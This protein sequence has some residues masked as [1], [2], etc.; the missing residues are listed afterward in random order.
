MEASNFKT[1]LKGRIELLFSYDRWNIGYIE[2]T[3]ESLIRTQKLNHNVYW[4]KEGNPEY[5][6]DPFPINIDNQLHIYY[7]EMSFWRGKGQLMMINTLDYKSKKKITGI[8]KNEIHLS[9]PYLFEDQGQWYCL[10]ETSEIEEV[11]LFKIDKK[12]PEKLHKL[13]PILSGKRYVDS[14]II[15][16]QDK[17]WLFTT[18]SGKPN[19]LYIFHSTKLN[20]K[21]HPHEL[22][23]IKM[24]EFTGRSAGR[25]FLVD[26]K[27]YLPC[28]NPE[29]CYGG[30][31]VIHELTNLSTTDFQYK[32]LFD[33]LPIAPYTKGLHTIN[34]HQDRII[35]DGKRMVF[36]PIA[37]L[38]KLSKKLRE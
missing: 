11:A 26:E 30:S 14:S 34:F 29:K 2:Q 28:Q 22:N 37:I 3:K 12:Q 5:A 24:D 17:Y 19:Q 20:E 25:P 35:I 27:L 33:I 13:R 16:Y 18:Q 32:K 38:K 31:V 10:P 15:F 7:E 23:P 21:F 36:S 6:A 4:L 8:S 9:Y 1:W